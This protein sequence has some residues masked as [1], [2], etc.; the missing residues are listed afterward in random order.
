Q[1]SLPKEKRA[2]VLRHPQIRGGF[3]ELLLCTDTGI[4]QVT[5]SKRNGDAY[6]RARKARAGDVLEIQ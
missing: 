5:I 6:K 4:R 3:V 2:R 1:H